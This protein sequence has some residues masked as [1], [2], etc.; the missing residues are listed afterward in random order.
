MSHKSLVHQQR[1]S[2]P[3]S[4][5]DS[6]LIG[7][8]LV[9]NETEVLGLSDTSKCCHKCVHTEGVALCKRRLC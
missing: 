5:P 9:Q 7:L 2:T 3:A 4:C 6:F 8:Q 1:S